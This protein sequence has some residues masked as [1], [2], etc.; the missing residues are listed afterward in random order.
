MIQVIL[1]DSNGA[2]LELGDV[3]LYRF[4]NPKTVAIGTLRFN[5]D[6]ADFVC[7]DEDGKWWSFPNA[8][9]TSERLCRIEDRPELERCLG[10]NLKLTKKL[11]KDLF[12][13]KN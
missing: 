10:E 3:L 6:S 7:T 9:G 2:E 5:V 8:F 4:P 12:P 11:E 1:T 13:Q